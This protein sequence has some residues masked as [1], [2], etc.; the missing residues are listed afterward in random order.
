MEIEVGEYVRLARNQGINKII[1]EDDDGFLVLDEIIADEYGEECFE[2]SLQDVDK[3]IVK[4]SKNIINLIEVGDIIEINKEKYEV[5]FDKS[6]DKLGVLIP[7]RDCLEI[8]HSSLEHIFM[9]YED[10]KIL[11]KEQYMQNCYT[12]ERKE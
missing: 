1:D 8:R 11:T 10:I 5:I 4:H 3:E 6:I 9:E 2:I 12:V 7:N